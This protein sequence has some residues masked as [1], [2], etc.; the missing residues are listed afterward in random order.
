MHSKQY[1]NTVI[2]MSYEP[3]LSCGRKTNEQMLLF[4]FFAT[5][6]IEAK[7]IAATQ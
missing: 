4:V 1:H 7:V 2:N 5:K 3:S 6:Y